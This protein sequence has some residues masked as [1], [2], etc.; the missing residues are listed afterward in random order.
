MKEEKYA[1]TCGEKKSGRQDV[2]GTPGMEA[3]DDVTWYSRT[4]SAERERERESFG[5]YTR[6]CPGEK[7]ESNW[8]ART[9]VEEYLLLNERRCVWPMET[10]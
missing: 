6:R 8:S 3:R 9:D 7:N 2:A 4:P 5:I 1:R 10:A